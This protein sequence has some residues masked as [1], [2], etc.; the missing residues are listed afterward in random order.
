MKTIKICVLLMI[1]AFITNF[2]YA[3]NKVELGVYGG[4]TAPTG[5]LGDN[6]NLSFHFGVEGVLKVDGTNNFYADIAYNNLSPKFTNPD[7]LTFSETEISAG[8]RRNIS[9][10]G[11]T[12]SNLLFFDVGAGAY[13]GKTSFT[14]GNGTVSSVSNT[15]FGINFGL[16]GS[17]P[18]GASS[19]FIAKAKFHNA[20]TKGNNTNFFTL[21]AGVNFDLN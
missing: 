20:F 3:Q 7:N 2:S 6:F 12:N 8:Y 13:T 19:D 10:F 9:T 11:T 14:S 5:T 16:G 17:F 18:L 1:M 15:D 4:L 21:S